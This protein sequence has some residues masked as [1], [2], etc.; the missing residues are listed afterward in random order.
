[1]IATK[2][3]KEEMVLI[4]VKAQVLTFESKLVKNTEQK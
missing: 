2:K 4:L 3:V 1:M